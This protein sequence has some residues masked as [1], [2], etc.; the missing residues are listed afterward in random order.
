[1][2]KMSHM[3]IFFI[4]NNYFDKFFN[5]ILVKL[6]KNIFK[7]INLNI[8]PTFIGILSIVLYMISFLYFF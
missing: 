5:I 4:F 7:D 3:R 8:N 1:M 6:F 2:C